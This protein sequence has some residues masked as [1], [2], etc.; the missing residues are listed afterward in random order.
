MKKVWLAAFF[1]AAATSAAAADDAGYDVTSYP[2]VSSYDAGA[3][4]EDFS[5]PKG[6]EIKI[7]ADPDGSVTI[8]IRLAH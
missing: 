8:T 4:Y 7:V 5:C 3:S 6:Q 2:D 1:A